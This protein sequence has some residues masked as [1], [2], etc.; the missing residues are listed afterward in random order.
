M[1]AFLAAD[2]AALGERQSTHGEYYRGIKGEDQ[3][4][5]AL[6]RL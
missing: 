3:D 5:R 1:A 4:L 6:M 2:H